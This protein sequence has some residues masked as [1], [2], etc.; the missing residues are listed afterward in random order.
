MEFGWLSCWLA[1]PEQKG[2]L[3]GVHDIQEHTQIIQTAVEGAQNKRTHLS[4]V[5]LDLRNVFGSI[6]HAILAEM[7][8]SLPIPDILRRTLLEIYSGNVMNFF[9]G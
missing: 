4:L 7:L 8:G 2:F 5:W 9:V 3:S 6:P 1:P